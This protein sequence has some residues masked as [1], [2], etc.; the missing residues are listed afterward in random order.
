MND[1]GVEAAIR[2]LADREAIRE[3][4]CR[5]ANCVWQKDAAGVAD[6]FAPNGVMDM[7]D[8]PPVQGRQALHDEYQRTLP[9][10]DLQPFV[11]NH[12]IELDGDRA[13][14]TCTLDLRA[15]V[16]G[17]SMIG[18]GFYRD[19]YVRVEGAWKFEARKLTMQFLAPLREGWVEERG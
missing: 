5:Y 7:G 19:V 4:V 9:H 12:V 11:H 14:G 10:V 1:A 3:L 2:A 13:T 18:A 17:N 15:A 16:G 8:R 6:L